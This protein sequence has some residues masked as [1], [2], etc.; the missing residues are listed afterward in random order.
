MATPL[1]QAVFTIDKDVTEFLIK[2]GGDVQALDYKG[3]TPLQC[4]KHRYRVI[5]MEELK[6]DI[7]KLIDLLSQYE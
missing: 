1:H 7:Q 6:P 4:A 5:K 2:N 3:R